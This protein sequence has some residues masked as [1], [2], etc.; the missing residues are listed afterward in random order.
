MHSVEGLV[1]DMRGKV[2]YL[3]TS[4]PEVNKNSAKLKSLDTW[5]KLGPLSLDFIKN[6]ISYKE[7]LNFTDNQLFFMDTN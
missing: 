3:L 4:E 7:P 5:R 1:N 6:N 2:E